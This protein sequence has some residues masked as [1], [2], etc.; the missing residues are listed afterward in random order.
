MQKQRRREEE[1]R[2]GVVRLVLRAPDL[3]LLGNGG[4]AE[5]NERNRS[6]LEAGRS[7]DDADHG[8]EGRGGQHRAEVEPSGARQISH[9]AL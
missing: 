7:D 4:A 9:I 6:H 5:Q 8:S 1:N 2:R 3:E